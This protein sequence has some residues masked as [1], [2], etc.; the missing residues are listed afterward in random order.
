MD[1]W[2]R[3]AGTREGCFLD[4]G[5]S[6]VDASIVCHEMRCLNLD[7][8]ETVWFSLRDLSQADREQFAT[9]GEAIHL[10]S[11]Q[12]DTTLLMR[13]WAGMSDNS[14]GRAKRVLGE[15]R[16]PMHRLV[17]RCNACLYYTWMLL[18]SPGLNDSIASVGML[19]AR[20]DGEAF[21]QALTN[22]PRQLSQP[23]V[24]LSIIR[25]SYFPPNGQQLLWTEDMAHEA[26][27][28]FWGC[29]LRSQQQHLV[30]YKVQALQN[31]QTK[32]SD[33]LQATREELS[34]I[35]EQL[36]TQAERSSANEELA[37]LRS[38]VAELEAAPEKSGQQVSKEVS[39]LQAELLAVSNEANSKIDAANER[40]RAVR[41]ERDDAKSQL[42]EC[43]GSERRNSSSDNGEA[44][45]QRLSRLLEEQMR[46]AQEHE[47]LVESNKRLLEREVQA[48][49]KI[50][51]LENS[52]RVLN[53]REDKIAEFEVRDRLKQ[54]RIDAL[55]VKVAELEGS[56]QDRS[57]MQAATEADASDRQRLEIEN[58][59]TKLDQV[60]AE[61]NTK[62]SA[63]NDRIRE[64]KQ[65]RNDLKQDNDVL[66]SRN[67]ELTIGSEGNDA[68][69]R[70]FASLQAAN[71][72]REAELA[73]L[74]STLDSV[75]NHGKEHMGSIAEQVRMLV[76]DK[77]QLMREAAELK[78][79]NRRLRDNMASLEA[80]NASVFEQKEALMKI[81]EDLHQACEGTESSE[82][83]ELGRASVRSI[84]Q[85]K[86]LTPR[87]GT[88]RL[89]A[90]IN[91]TPR[92]SFSLS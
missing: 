89:D 91:L 3:L 27:I 16:I 90:T 79:E 51:D 82:I 86:P 60:S 76:R 39:E 74:K 53:P 24:C 75:C 5:S 65:E 63:A 17:S 47:Q 77:D 52:I 50:A 33:P 42:E 45:D 71:K 25:T 56:I 35:R 4:P 87:A 6:K 14:S 73:N 46:G 10:K 38:R 36:A 34:S 30:M 48:A 58:L 11:L 57:T 41:K 81:V 28:A 84:R 15:L 83:Q 92:G 31:N 85:F 55:K 23:G 72:K 67:A 29:L 37:R 78:D 80:E 9:C 64:I 88:P 8:G 7:K 13:T 61:A 12:M 22:A 2:Q 59:R 26:R 44:S 69:S 20:D 32:A 62:I 1:W 66:T 68:R 19:T 43:R 21:D 49:G 40:I 54:E 18:E 70:E